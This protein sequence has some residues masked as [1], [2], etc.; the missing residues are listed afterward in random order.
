[1]ALQELD[2]E[3]GYIPGKDNSIAD[4]MS[5]LCIN[6]MPKKSVTISAIQRSKPLSQIIMN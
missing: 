6:N 5:R 4:A 2:F 1:M 3:I